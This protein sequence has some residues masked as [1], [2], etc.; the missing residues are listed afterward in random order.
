MAIG[1]PLRMRWQAAVCPQLLSVPVDCISILDGRDQQHQVLG[2]RRIRVINLNPLPVPCK[3]GIAGVALL[4][5]GLIGT[6][7]FPPRIVQ[8]R[9]GPRLVVA[10]VKPP[11]FVQGEPSLSQ[12][13]PPSGFGLRP[14]EPGRE[15]SESERNEARSPRQPGH[16]ETILRLLTEADLHRWMYGGQNTIRVSQATGCYLQGGKPF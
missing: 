5:P 11:A 7:R 3:A 4:S 15:L 13:L 9:I 8:G 10:Q 12:D 6:D 2:S 14:G 1:P 16:N